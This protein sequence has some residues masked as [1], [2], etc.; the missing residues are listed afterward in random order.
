M[1]S[2]K[3]IFNPYMGLKREIYILFIS[4]LVNALGAFIFPFMTLLLK[5]KIGLDESAVGLFSALC[6][7]V[8]A[9][10]SLIGGKI[11]DTIG[12]KKILV[13]FESLGM[14]SY[15]ICIFLEP[16]MTMV[17]MLMS[18]SFFFGV[19]GPSHD[20]MVADL[21]S[22]E[23]RQGAYSLLYLG[24]NLGFAVA[25][26]FAGRLFANHLK[27]MFAI[28]AATAFLAIGLIAL[29]VKETYNPEE[30]RKIAEESTAKGNGNLE[31]HSNEP[32]FKVL[33]NRPVLLYFAMAIFGYRF[34][35]SQWSFMMPL[36]ASSNFGEAGY[37]LYGAL[38]SINALVVVIFTPI[39]TSLFSK[40]T[41]IK[42]IIYAGIL[43]TLGFGMLG[44][45]SV[46][47]AFYA[48]VV[49]FTLGE[50][51]EAISVMP[52]I[53]NHTP[54]SHRGRM[55]SV[56]PMIMGAGYSLGPFVMG[57]VLEGTS[58]EYSWKLVGIIVLTATVFMGFL[59][60]YDRRNHDL[61]TNKEGS[62]V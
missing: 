48:S 39:L 18:V 32:I 21:A 13:I 33:L 12:R 45:I 20:A 40:E 31:A 7:L 51:L 60:L 44:F 30:S 27:L 59:E 52:F 26:L 37:T 22:D 6:G 25:M 43:F 4:R 10:A 24:F 17:Y 38:G 16:G 11:S 58:F 57:M 47:L 2:F 42:R 55:S 14:A 28:D 34:V 56:L 41:N 5:D 61:S 54:A 62:T 15:L 19:A 49:I 46:E 9:P 3:E 36:H 29:F 8:Y 50:I 53:M 35:Y 1:K 23:E